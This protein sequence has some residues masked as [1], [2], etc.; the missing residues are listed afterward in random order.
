M[1]RNYPELDEKCVLS[2]FHGQLLNCDEDFI[3]ATLS[4]ARYLTVSHAIC[5]RKLPT[6]DSF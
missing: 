4:A 2:L 1:G 3:Q 5:I 6:V